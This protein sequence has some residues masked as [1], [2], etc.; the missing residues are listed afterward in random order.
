MNVFASCIHPYAEKGNLGDMIG[1]IIMEFYCKTRGINVNRLGIKDS[2]SENTIAIVGSIYGKCISKSNNENMK[3]IIIGCGF[4]NKIGNVQDKNIIC[5][6][7]RGPLTKAILNK[8]VP[9][10]SDPG[11]LISVIYPL[12]CVIDKTDIGYIIHSVDREVFFKMF[13]EKKIHLIDNY[14]SYDIFIDQ[15]SKYKSVISSSLHGI[16]FCHSYNIPVYSIK[17]TNNVIGN[18]FKFIDYYHS[19]GNTQY[20]GRHQVNINTN[21]TNLIQNA[22]QPSKDY[23][24]EIKKTQED[25]ICSCIDEYYH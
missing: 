7:V 11:L 3:M 24:N 15:L 21:F 23:I 16:I 13:P 18:N 20:K 25:I 22:W 8:S 14:S 9:I 10:I 17:V 5:K 6:G 12:P 2:I 1:Y 19:I 4:I